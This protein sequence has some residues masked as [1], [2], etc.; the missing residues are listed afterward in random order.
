M[1][2]RASL[3]SERPS[4]AAC[5]VPPAPDFAPLGR[6]RQMRAEARH[7]APAHDDRAVVSR[8]S[9]VEQA[10]EQ[11]RAHAAVQ[12]GAA[13]EQSAQGLAPGQNE[14]RAHEILGQPETDAA[15][16]VE[17]VTGRTPRA[18]SHREECDALEETAQIVLEDHHEN[19]GREGDEALKQRGQQP[20][21][22]RGGRPEQGRHGCD[23]AQRHARPR[24]TNPN[25]R[26]PAESG[27]DEDVQYIC[28][29][30]IGDCKIQVDLDSRSDFADETRSSARC[31]GFRANRVTGGLAH[32]QWV[33]ETP[34]ASDPLQTEAET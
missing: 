28:E 15:E 23:A 30:K 20:Q 29:T 22:Q 14:E 2:Q 17:H 3:R 34:V 21:L 8:R 13:V 1:M 18:V 9:R 7:L 33:R 32:P 12:I 5:R 27:H 26:K 19:Q 25:D 16:L 24:L 11:R 31:G 6:K 4:P 10:P